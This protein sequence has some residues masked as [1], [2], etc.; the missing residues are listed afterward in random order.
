MLIFL[1]AGP[2]T[3]PLRALP[4]ACFKPNKTVVLVVGRWGQIDCR[5]ESLVRAHDVAENCR[6]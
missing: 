6:N 5:M 4:L 1:T 2:G 3:Q